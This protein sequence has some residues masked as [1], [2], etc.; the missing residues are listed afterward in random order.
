[1]HPTPLVTSAVTLALA[2]SALAASPRAARAGDD[3]ARASLWVGGSVDLLPLGSLRVAT[4]RGGTQSVDTETAVGIGGLIEVA[5]RA[6]VS[7]GLAPRLVLGLRTP[8][9]TSSSTQLDLRGRIAVGTDVAS[10]VGVYGVVAPGY[11]FIFPASP[12]PATVTRPRGF[13]LDLGGG[14]VYRVAP[15][16]ALTAEVGYQLGFH[17]VGDGTVS[18]TFAD[19]LLHLGIGVLAAL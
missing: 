15:R 16:L 13:I 7:A 17:H 10:A 9:D 8:G 2:M 1:M 19:D 6:H 5:T 3:A 18:V 11:S 4:S 14:V 12:W